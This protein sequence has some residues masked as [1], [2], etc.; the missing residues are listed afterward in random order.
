[1]DPFRKE[2][3]VL[4]DA[5]KA[6]VYSTKEKASDLFDFVNNHYGSL[7]AG[8]VQRNLS[9]FKTKLEEAVMWA[10]KGMSA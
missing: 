6:V 3:R 4:T 8:D 10:I 7:P 1:M 9:L 2:Y 5:E